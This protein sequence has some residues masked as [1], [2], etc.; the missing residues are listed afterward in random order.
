MP[1]QARVTIKDSQWLSYIATTYAELT[2]G[3][4]GLAAI[5]PGN[6]TLFVL[7]GD[8][9]V[10]I[11]TQGLYFPIDIIFI[12]SSFRVVEVIT[13]VS[14]GVLLSQEIPVRYFLEMNAGEAEGI[15]RGDPV[16]IELVQ[17]AA[18]TT[19]WIS[20]V[21]SFTGVMMTGAMMV[22]MGKIMADAVF[23]KKRSVLYGP[24]GERLLPQTRGKGKFVLKPDR[25][26]NII[27]THTERTG[28]VFLQ[29]ESDK[30]LVY[31]LL[32]K[33]ERK[34]LDAGWLIEIQDTEPRASILD[35]LWESSSHLPQT[36]RQK[37]LV[38][39]YKD[40]T[41]SLEAHEKENE[42]VRKLGKRPAYGKH[43]GDII[44][45]RK[46]ARYDVTVEAWQERDRLGIWI[47][48]KRTDKTV[49]EWWDEDAREMFEQGF[50]KPGVPQ[51]SREKPGR[52]FVDSVLDYAESV[53]LLAGGRHLPQAVRDACYWTA[54]NKVTGE[55]TESSAPYTS[56]SRALRGGKAFA[57]RHWRGT[58]LVEVWKQPG[59]YS[60]ELMIEPVVSEV[61]TLEKSPAVIPEHP[62]P[63]RL[64]GG[65][66]FLP[67]S[68]EF[69]AYTI[70]DIGYRDKIDNAFK[71]AIARAKRG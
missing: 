63:P 38:I 3:L 67:D 21:V 10:G 64:K 17:V 41:G 6:G 5:P 36:I 27:M 26:G 56:S 12:S 20:P 51:Y 11:T 13:G 43:P 60:E 34:D 68:P 40:D 8:Q 37:H 25:M 19:D 39:L 31:G 46:P 57:S 44:P 23:P 22:K 9:P 16:S 71:E 55:I 33:G 2:T 24:R 1:G 48:D 66:E 47:T 42:R 18:G 28:D 69:L 15:E 54:I 65:L 59:R 61:V 14:P 58:A 70:E 53:G 62:Q 4:K 49:T 29:F 45:P 7:P 32:R 52:E 30:E 50:F 35:E